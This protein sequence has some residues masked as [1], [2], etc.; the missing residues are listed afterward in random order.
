MISFLANLECKFCQ[1]KTEH[2]A[3]IVLMSVTFACLDFLQY[4]SVQLHYI[5]LHSCKKCCY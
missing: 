5:H 1:T 4:I 2:F 3:Y